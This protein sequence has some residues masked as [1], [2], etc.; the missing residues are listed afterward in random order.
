MNKTLKNYRHGDICLIGVEKLPN[1][2]KPSKTNLL[3][4]VSSGGEPHTFKD[5]TF[6][7][8]RNGDF[9]IG[10]LEAKDTRLYHPKHGEK[11]VGN[12]KEAVIKDGVYEVRVQVEDTNEGF[13]QVID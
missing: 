8:K 7:S 10:Y 9:I 3:I 1:N 6:Y 5:G 12:L 11:K 2:L 13:R 4:E